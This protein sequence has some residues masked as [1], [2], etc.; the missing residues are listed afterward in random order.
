M[1]AVEGRISPPLADRRQ[2][3]VVRH[4]LLQAGFT[5]DGIGAVLGVSVDVLARPAE[6]AIHLRRLRDAGPL[7]TLIRL[8]LLDEPVEPSVVEDALGSGAK[9]LEA[10]RL[11]GL[12]DGTVRG[13]VRLVPHGRIVIASDLPDRERTHPDHVAG[14]H[15]PSLTL[16]DLT[17][18][19]PVRSAL[20]VGTGCGIQAL[21]A[22]RH[23]DRV[24]ATDVNER[25]L[26][27][28]AFN[29]AVN[30]I[31]N[32]EFRLGSFFEPVAG[33]TFGLVV[34]NPPYVISPET[35]YIFRDS[36][37]G[38]D[39]VSERLVGELPAY[40]EEGGFGTIM[41]SWIQAGDDPAARPRAWLE[42]TGCDAWIL[43]TA[44]EDPLSAA[45]VWNRD[46]SSDQAD[47]GEA[48]DRWMA[49][50]AREGI[51][52]L[53]YGALIL[54]KRS[55]GPNWVR[56]REL[57]DSS[58]HD[59]ADHVLRLFTGLDASADLSDEAL[60]A[61]R[62]R[63]ADGAVIRTEH[64][65]VSDGWDETFEMGISRGVPFTAQ[66]DQMTSAFLSRLD[67]SLSLGEV[68]DAFAVSNDA[69]PAEARAS[70]V[71]IARE[72][73]E[74]GLAVRAGTADAEDSD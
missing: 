4:L 55:G 42:G 60:A 20:D 9:A 6:R 40:L 53:A 26:A 33:E 52:A 23:A 28:A 48:I 27:F 58:R 1:T 11:V 74:L 47:F 16:G 35:E 49:Y 7:E 59:P 36:G 51:E 24:V 71:R 43:H 30:G 15:R 13:L 65:L 14:L 21:L 68:L 12:V 66:L 62:L 5:R 72:L 34:S 61:A 37:L 19:W 10:L 70:G 8:F 38:R 69:P 17:V 31:D 46:R 54:R 25:A 41:V 50:F 44:G 64:R 63:L 2:A 39:R 73:L 22:A 29:A 18:R 67:G 56:S 57:P 45:A 32:V 3:T